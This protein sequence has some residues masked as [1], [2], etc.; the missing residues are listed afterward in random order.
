ML[1]FLHRK[2]QLSRGTY[3]QYVSLLFDYISVYSYCMIVYL[4]RASWHSSAALTEFLP[5]VLLSCKANARV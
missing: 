3:D 5:C 4:H 1:V 2:P